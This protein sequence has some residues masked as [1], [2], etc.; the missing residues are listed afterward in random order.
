VTFDTSIGGWAFEAELSFKK[1]KVGNLWL[2]ISAFGS[3]TSSKVGRCRLTVLKTRLD[4]V[5]AYS[6]SA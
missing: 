2:E 3:A 4:L 1:G 5:S 6:F